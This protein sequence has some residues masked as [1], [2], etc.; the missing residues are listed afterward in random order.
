MHFPPYLTMSINNLRICMYFVVVSPMYFVSSASTPSFSVLF[1]FSWVNFI[2][3]FVPFLHRC[4]LLK[5]NTWP[6]KDFE[7][8][9]TII[10][11]FNYQF[12][13]TIK[14]NSTNYFRRKISQSKQMLILKC[15]IIFSFPF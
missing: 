15:K 14:I 7:P 5:C 12:Y 9:Q 11:N 4:H 8:N 13:I 6:N 2:V 1:Y 10:L 3:F